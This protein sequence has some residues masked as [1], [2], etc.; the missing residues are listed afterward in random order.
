VKQEKIYREI[1]IL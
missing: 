1:K